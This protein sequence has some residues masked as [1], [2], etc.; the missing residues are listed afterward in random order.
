VATSGRGISGGLCG[1]GGEGRVP[2]IPV[3]A[4]RGWVAAGLRR[5]LG[6]AVLRHGEVA[7]E[8]ISGPRDSKS[9]V[10]EVRNRKS[11]SAFAY[12]SRFSALTDYRLLAIG[13]AVHYARRYQRIAD[14]VLLDVPAA[15][16]EE[17]EE[18]PGPSWRNPEHLDWMEAVRRGVALR[19]LAL[20]DV[21]LRFGTAT[22]GQSNAKDRSFWLKLIPG[23]GRA[24][25]AFSKTR[26]PT[27]ITES[28]GSPFVCPGRLGLVTSSQYVSGVSADELERKARVVDLLLG[29]ARELG[30]GLEPERVYERFRELL[31]GVIPHDGLVISSYDPTEGLIRCDYVWNEGNVIDPTSLPPLPLNPEGG[32]QSRVI[33]SGKPFLFTDVEQE[34]RDQGGVYYNVDKQGRMERIPDAGPPRTKSAMMVPVRHDGD[35]VGVVQL[36]RDRG[37]YGGND[38]ELFEALVAQ[39]STAVRNARL[40]RERRRLEAAEAAARAVAAER[41]QAA[42]VLEAIGD[43][44]FVLDADGVVQFWNRAAK[45]MTG[46]AADRLCGTA[47][48]AVL[49]EWPTL[50]QRISIAHGH[51]VPRPA[52][53]P[54]RIGEHDL[55]LS[56]V[57]VESAAG[58]IYAFRDL[59]E[60]VRLEEEKSDF[61]ATISHE[62]RTP[63]AAVYGAATTL[64]HR[65]EELGRDHRR[66]LLEMLAAEAKRL[67]DITEE[68]LLTSQIDHGDVRLDQQPIDVADVVRTTIATMES[69]LQAMR[70]DLEIPSEL[71][72]AAGDADRLRQVL[73]N[74]LDNAVK[75]SDA[76][77]V[78]VRVGIANGQIFIAVGDEGRGIAM[79]DHERIFEKFYRADPQLR[80]APSGTGLGLYIA[81]E[82]TERM[83][84]SLALTSEP[85]RG[86]TFTIALPRAQSSSAAART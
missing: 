23:G 86:S 61:V 60:E 47:L 57:A 30:E 29:A 66:A 75:Y 70:L 55:W 35:V 24:T 45:L 39:M 44:V 4:A 62:L 13:I 21:P 81:R 28:D 19:P 48:A 72:A 73:V 2:C 26:P 64:L 5:F 27:R 50:S 11:A 74:L 49:P 56:F 82:L 42:R 10:A 83:G 37:E 53:V 32:M 80:H 31:V 12:L 67:A 6:V 36:M 43:G 9:S 40:Q 18:F 3:D 71:P 78:S 79:A 17:V 54:V 15:N 51:E 33:V 65:D 7:N 25:R 76:D 22:K 8:S 58:V 20:R 84:G 77:Q 68:V 46:L 52:T 59:S 63:M 85:G 14:V 1:S 69:Q 16:L 34:V 41:E 38:V